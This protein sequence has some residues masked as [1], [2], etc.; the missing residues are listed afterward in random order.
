MRHFIDSKTEFQRRNEG[1]VVQVVVSPDSGWFDGHFPGE[2]ILPGVAQVAMVTEILAEWLQK[3]VQVQEISR[4]RFKSAIEPQ[5]RVKVEVA[6]REGTVH[7]YDFRLWKKNK[8]ACSGIIK[9]APS[10]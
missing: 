1:A 6:L 4:V 10:E 9:L 2:P 7:H 3:P 5:E 8:L